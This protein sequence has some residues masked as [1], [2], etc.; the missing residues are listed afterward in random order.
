M[1]RAL[2]ILRV[3]LFTC[4]MRL[5]TTLRRRIICDN[6]LS[7]RSA[8]LTD[9]FPPTASRPSLR[10]ADIRSVDVSE[11][12]SPGLDQVTLTAG[13]KSVT[14][15][16]LHP[17]LGAPA[18]TS[19]SCPRKP[20]ASLRQR[21]HRDA[22]CRSAITYIDGDAACCCIAATRSSSSPRSRTSSRSLPA[23]E[24]RTAEQG[25]VREFEHEVTHHTMMHEAFRTSCT[26]SATTRIRWRC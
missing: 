22:S 4:R 11:S 26:A 6:S 20:A 2:V 19:A 10:R 16:V 25:R 1:R 15:P 17:T 12:P 14:L 7:R 23:D 9:C 13:D 3:A 5:G 8:R 24:R 18:S 21:F